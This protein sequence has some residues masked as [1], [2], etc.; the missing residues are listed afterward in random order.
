MI[1]QPV[2]VQSRYCDPSH[3][4]ELLDWRPEISLEEGF[5]RVLQAACERVRMLGPRALD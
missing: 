5:R 2:G 3:L 1:G 4:V